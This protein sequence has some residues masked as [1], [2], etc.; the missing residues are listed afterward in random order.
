MCRAVKEMV[1]QPYT[2]PEHYFMQLDPQAQDL[3]T[4]TGVLVVKA[5]AADGVGG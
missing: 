5:V 4:P 3:D 2:L 1:L